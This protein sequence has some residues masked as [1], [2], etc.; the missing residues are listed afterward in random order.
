M[1]A[2]DQDERR[3]VP[4]CVGLGGSAVPVAEV[5]DWRITLADDRAC[6]WAHYAVYRNPRYVREHYST[7]VADQAIKLTS[8]VF[9]RQPLGPCTVISTESR[10]MSTS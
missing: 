9:E 2:L 3:K 5:D 10:A 4:K 7:S 1:V 8:W 6:H